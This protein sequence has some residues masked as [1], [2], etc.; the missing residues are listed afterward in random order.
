MKQTVTGE[1]AKKMNPSNDG[2]KAYNMYVGEVNGI[3]EHQIANGPS[4]LSEL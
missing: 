3:M 1:E 4:G 2:Q